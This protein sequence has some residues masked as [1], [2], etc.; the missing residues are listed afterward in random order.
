MGKIIWFNK[1]T[2]RLRQIIERITI[3]IK[4]LR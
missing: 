1:K 2:R 3:T 4:K